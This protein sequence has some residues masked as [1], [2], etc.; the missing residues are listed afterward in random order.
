MRSSL[1][2]A[3]LLL[4]GGSSLGKAQ[5]LRLITSPWP[6]AASLGANGEPVGLGVSI[7]EALKEHLGVNTPIEVLPWARGY[8]LAKA[9]PNIMLFT[10]GMTQ[11]RIDMGFSFIGPAIMWTHVLMAAPGRDLDVQGLADAKQQNLV[12][13]GV[14][15]S[16][17]LNLMAEAG[18]T[19]VET[20]DHQT[21]ARMLLA[22]R[23]DLWITSKLQASV[24]LDGI[25]V[26]ASSVTPVNTIRRAPSYLMISNGTDPELISKWRQAYELMASNGVLQ[27]TAQDWSA[28][29]GI[30]LIHDSD[31]GFA[32]S[33]SAAASKKASGPS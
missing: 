31:A 14:R 2:A 27:K 9:N 17:Q 25:G 18:L 12:V 6:P 28:R 3:L 15:D 33:D 22:K 23:V 20:A 32:A 7:V 1:F 10:G 26:S 11:E 8:R 13:A 19:T 21:G 24:V 4:S 5:E 29:L 16:W 30:P